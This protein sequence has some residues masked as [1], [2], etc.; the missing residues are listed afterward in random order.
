MALGVSASMAFLLLFSLVVV[1]HCDTLQADSTTN[2]SSSYSA[3]VPAKVHAVLDAER[4]LSLPSSVAEPD[5]DRSPVE[6]VAEPDPDRSPVEPV[7]EPDPDRSH[8]DSDEDKDEDEEEKEKAN[9][10]Q[11]QRGEE[12]NQ[13]AP[14]WRRQGEEGEAVKEAPPAKR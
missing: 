8:P 3:V 2:A 6:P 14:R 13:E 7:V 4:L 12:E 10:K 9:A 5:P 1:S 11:E